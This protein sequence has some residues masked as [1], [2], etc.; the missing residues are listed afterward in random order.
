MNLENQVCSLELAKKLKELDVKQES[1]FSW[2]KGEVRRGNQ[3]T[4]ELT[5]GEPPVSAFTVAELGNILYPK[6]EKLKASDIPD[7][8]ILGDE[9]FSQNFKADFW[10]K[11]LVYLLE[12]K[13]ITL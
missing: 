12:N 7:E 2:Y 4:Q 6:I 8:F 1:L 5:R 11:M 9:N 13:L 3:L 10:A